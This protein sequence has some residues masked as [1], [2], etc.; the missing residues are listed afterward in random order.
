MPSPRLAFSM[1]G[2]E[3]VDAVAG[4]PSLVPEIHKCVLCSVRLLVLVEA[5]EL[6]AGGSGL[7]AINLA[8]PFLRGKLEQRTQL[9]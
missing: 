7:C 9:P 8:W 4:W 2:K 5:V 6:N 1:A 3:K